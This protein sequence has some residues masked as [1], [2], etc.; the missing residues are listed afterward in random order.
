MRRLRA[1]ALSWTPGATPW[2]E[3]TTSSPS[4]TSV[5]SSTKIAPRS[6]ELLDDVLVVDDLLAHVDRRPVQVERVLDRLHGPVDAR[7]VAARRR[8]QDPRRGACGDADHHRTRVAGG[9]AAS[10]GRP[11]SSL[12]RRRTRRGVLP[13]GSRLLRALD[14]NVRRRH[15]RGQQTPHRFADQTSTAPHSKSRDPRSSAARDR[16]DVSSTRHIL[17]EVAGPQVQRRG[18]ER[19]TRRAR[20]Q[21]ASQDRRSASGTVA[22]DGAAFEALDCTPTAPWPARRLAL[23]AIRGIARTA[24]SPTASRLSAQTLSSVSSAVCQ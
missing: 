23:A 5:S 7:A 10:C 9:R 20:D 8:E 17:V 24:A 16:R 1:A 13:A 4:G 6:R 14:V 2:A 19:P 15:H 11:R 3:K 21:A 12:R 18:Q 22:Y